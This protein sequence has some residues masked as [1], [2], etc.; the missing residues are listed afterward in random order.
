MPDHVARI[1]K[2]LRGT[3]RTSALYWWFHDHYEEIVTQQEGDKQVSWVTVAASLNALG[4]RVGNGKL[5]T[6]ATARK[7]FNRVKADKAKLA[8]KQE[9]K[10]Q[11][12]VAPRVSMVPARPKE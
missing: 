11:Q 7:N 6:N 4:I 10:P 2:A 5:V 1:R 3:G 9:A 12:R 8:V